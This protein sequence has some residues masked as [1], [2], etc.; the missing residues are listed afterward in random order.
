M[1]RS[2][3]TEII[4]LLLFDLYEGGQYTRLNALGVVVVALV[5]TIKTKEGRVECTS[6]N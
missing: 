1:G 3:G 2:A 5:T 6:R 4:P